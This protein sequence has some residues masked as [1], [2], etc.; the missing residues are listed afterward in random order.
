MHS[1][2]V[3]GLTLRPLMDAGYTA[4]RDGERVGIARLVEDA[5]EVECDEPRVREVL[6]GRLEADARAAGIALRVAQREQRAA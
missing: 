2:W 3:D 6:R 5:I 1:E 4:W